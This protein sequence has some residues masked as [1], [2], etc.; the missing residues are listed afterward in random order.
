MKRLLLA[1][2]APLLLQVPVQAQSPV[3]VQ[4]RGPD[5][6]QAAALLQATQATVRASAQTF[7]LPNGLRVVHLEDHEH[8]LVRVLLR[9]QLEPAD[10]PAGLQGLPDLTLRLLSRSPAGDLKADTFERSLAAA[11][12]QFEA[13][14]TQDHMEWQLLA[15]SRDQD[16]ALGLLTERLART[17]LDPALLELQR[18]D[19]WRETEGMDLPP[20]E[21][22]ARLLRLD[23]TRRPSALSLG[24]ISFEDILSFRGQVFRP[25]RA[26]LILHGD[27]GLEQ[28]K[29]LLLLNLGAWP[30]G[31]SP[32]RPPGPTAATNAIDP[33]RI[34]TGE[35]GLRLQAW[36]PRPATVSPESAALLNLL[37]EEPPTQGILRRVEASGLEWTL[38][39]VGANTPGQVLAQLQAEV[40][41]LR[42]RRFS[43]ADLEQARRVYLARRP[44]EALH[45][46]AQ[47]AT[48]LANASGAGIRLE[49]LQ[50]LQ[51]EEL[52]ADLA[53]WLQPANLRIGALGPAEA[54]K[55][56]PKP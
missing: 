8:P 22:L 46:E 36:A 39:A 27:L 19:C 6:G 1:G 32:S 9:I 15:R 7:T 17:A 53:R 40:E 43:K 24:S 37:M 42:Q 34:T 52:Q 20:R 25:Q 35:A 50:A 44:L 45:P 51:P 10:T 56:L 33:I 41:T 14:C 13:T 49:G 4:A 54:L 26:L 18:L 30:P 11:G 12:I 2:A 16:Q 31:A 55:A 48:A 3:P 23:P 5:H 29:R 47:L 38:E 28:A 21:R